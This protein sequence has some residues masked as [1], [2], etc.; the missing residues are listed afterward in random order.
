MSTYIPLVIKKKN[1][2]NKHKKF[3]L[4]KKKGKTDLKPIET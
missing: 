4:Y 3:L 1:S 2:E